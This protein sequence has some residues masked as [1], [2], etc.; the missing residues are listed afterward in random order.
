MSLLNLFCKTNEQL[1][2]TE[3]SRTLNRDI[4]LSI[5]S[6]CHGNKEA[7]S[8][9]VKIKKHKHTLNAGLDECYTL[10]FI[11]TVNISLINQSGMEGDVPVERCS[12][13]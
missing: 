13:L 9:V 3:R 2:L 1:Y 7:R 11:K 8:H 6:C 4:S 10:I 12:L 5:T